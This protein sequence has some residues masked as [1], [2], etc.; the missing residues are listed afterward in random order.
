MREN[1]V[2]NNK[3]LLNGLFLILII[4]FFYFFNLDKLLFFFCILAFIY[5]IYFS[6]ILYNS[7]FKSLLLVLIISL[8]FVFFI[9]F[10]IFFLIFIFLL[11]FVFFFK[12]FVKELFIFSLVFFFYVIFHIYSF[13]RNFIYII[14]FLS[15][16]NDTTAYIF[17]NL[18][19]GP[20][21]LPFISPKKT[22]SGTIFSSIFSLFFII[23]FFDFNFIFSFIFSTTFFFGDIYFSYFKR[24]FSIKDYSNLIPGHGGILDR[25][26][27]MFFSSIFL[28]FLLNN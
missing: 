17:G 8:S 25:V 20:L 12:K 9:P 7:N 6:K 16:L 23:I 21:I 10:N 3:R 26:D 14:I 24:F 19:K 28:L 13:D 4:S 15:F 2:I 11:T 1:L 27:S 22:W 5:D 18:I